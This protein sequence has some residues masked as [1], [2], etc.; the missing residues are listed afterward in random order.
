VNPASRAE[1][2]VF[3]R[4]P[5]STHLLS[6]VVQASPALQKALVAWLADR[7]TK[8]FIVGTTGGARQRTFTLG[9]RDLAQLRE[10]VMREAIGLMDAEARP[11]ASCSA[12]NPALREQIAQAWQEAS[13]A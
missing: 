10:S 5:Q 3:D 6:D 12:V 7:A 8:F 13:R 4:D 11:G 9:A 2:L 1:L